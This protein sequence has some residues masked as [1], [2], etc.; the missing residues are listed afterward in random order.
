MV[1]GK[2]EGVVELHTIS[3]YVTKTRCLDEFEFGIF[4]WVNLVGAFLWSYVSHV[5]QSSSLVKL[6][7]LSNFDDHLVNP[8]LPD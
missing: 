5:S 3:I 6:L 1:D 8:L 4:L 2:G 7:A